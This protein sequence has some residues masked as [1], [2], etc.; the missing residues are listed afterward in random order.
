MTT[1]R[2]HSTAQ[3]CAILGISRATLYTWGPHRVARAPGTRS[4]LMWTRA[5]II[6]LAADHD[7]KPDWTAA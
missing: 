7:R 6:R 5:D 1:P 4:T 2:Y 3:V